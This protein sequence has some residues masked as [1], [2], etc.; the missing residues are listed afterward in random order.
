MTPFQLL[1]APTGLAD[2]LALNALRRNMRRFAPWQTQRLPLGPPILTP[3][4]GEDSARTRGTVSV[5]V[6]RR[7]P[8]A[9][10]SGEDQVLPALGYRELPQP[11]K[12]LLNP[13]LQVSP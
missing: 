11:R 6:D 4:G 10:N 12:A 5:P 3:L 2:G 13:G 8:S 7:R 1:S 9:E